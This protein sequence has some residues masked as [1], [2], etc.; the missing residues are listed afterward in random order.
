MIEC[1]KY[2]DRKLSHEEL[3]EQK[4]EID[5]FKRA[6]KENCSTHWSSIEEMQEHWYQSRREDLDLECSK[7]KRRVGELRAVMVLTT[8]RH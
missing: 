1:I 6:Q 7:E 4:T 3:M 5:E 2:R 8:T